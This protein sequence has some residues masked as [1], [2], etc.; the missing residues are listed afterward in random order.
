VFTRRPRQ[1]TIGVSNAT[2]FTVSAECQTCLM[3]PSGMP[4]ISTEPPNWIG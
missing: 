1:P 2:A 3:D 4:I